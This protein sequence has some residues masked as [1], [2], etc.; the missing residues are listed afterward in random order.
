[1]SSNMMSDEAEKE[2]K[3]NEGASLVVGSSREWLV[4][5]GHAPVRPSAQEQ[6]WSEKKSFE[7]PPPL[8]CF[9]LSRFLALAS[10]AWITIL[11]IAN[12]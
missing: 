11:F 4:G 9:F 3:K 5:F 1:M 6:R 12:S 7:D 2:K 10:S 8:C